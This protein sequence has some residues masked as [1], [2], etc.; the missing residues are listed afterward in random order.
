MSIAAIAIVT[1][2]LSAVPL[3]LLHYSKPH[4][5]DGTPVNVVIRTDVLFMLILKLKLLYRYFIQ[6]SGVLAT[7]KLNSINVCI[8]EF[9]IACLMRF[10]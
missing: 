3:A 8:V 2:S 9:Q 6:I 5:T 7:N 4:S 10:S 1:N